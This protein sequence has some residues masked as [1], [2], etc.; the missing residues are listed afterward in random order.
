[1]LFSDHEVQ[2]VLSEDEIRAC[3]EFMQ[4]YIKPF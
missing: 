3:L 1:V 2:K 4:K